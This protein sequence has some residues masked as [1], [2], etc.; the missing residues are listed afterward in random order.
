MQKQIIY[1][2]MAGFF[3]QFIFTLSLLT[4]GTFPAC[5][6]SVFVSNASYKSDVTVY[7]TEDANEADLLVCWEKYAYQAKSNTGHWHTVAYAY[8]A[9]LKI[10]FT[11]QPSH[12]D[13]IIC[14]VSHRYRAGWRNKNKKHLLDKMK[15]TT[16]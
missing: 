13:L 15:S 1:H 14:I 10:Y 9:D 4:T 11:D 16:N 7:V 3:Y 12:A 6:Q 2:R 8:Q 5:A